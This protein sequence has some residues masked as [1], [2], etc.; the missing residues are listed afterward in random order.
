MGEFH[1]IFSKSVGSKEK[2]VNCDSF[3]I[4]VDVREKESLVVSH[5]VSL[6]F[7]VSFEKLEVGDY[8]VGGYAVERKTVSDFRASIFDKRLFSQMSNLSSFDKRLLLLEGSFSAMVEGRD[9]NLFRGTILS[10]VEKYRVPYVCTLDESDT[11]HC[12]LLLAK[13]ES[14]LRGKPSLR[15]SKKRVSLSDA[16]QFVLEGFPGVGPSLANKL[17]TRFGSVRNFCN[18]SYEELLSVEGLTP[19]K[20]ESLKRILG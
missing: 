11:A 18:A 2:V 14:K 3:S 7:S 10:V 19:L 1:N 9:K 12:L 6:G 5:L 20:V 8:L 13:R 17:L 16:K 4:V 15:A